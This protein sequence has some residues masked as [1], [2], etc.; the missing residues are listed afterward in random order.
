MYTSIQSNANGKITSAS[1]LKQAAMLA[2][3]L[4]LVAPV[5]ECTQAFYPNGRYGRRS[6]PSF[7]A[8]V[9]AASKYIC[10]LEIENIKKFPLLMT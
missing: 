5:A 7:E 8:E 1:W 2:V 6:D 9:E 4:C 3:V 10:H